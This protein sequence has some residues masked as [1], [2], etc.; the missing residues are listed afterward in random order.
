[1]KKIVALFSILVLSAFLATAQGPTSRAVTQITT[2]TTGVTIN[3]SR[4][5]IT[6][7]SAATAGAAVSSFTVTNSA[8]AATSTVIANVQGY[9]GTYTTNGLPVVTVGTVAAGSFV[10]NIINAHASNALAG[11]LNIGFIVE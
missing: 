10:V 3:S 8:V 7:V 4:G 9:S 6:T 11:T 5:V 1:M 2:I